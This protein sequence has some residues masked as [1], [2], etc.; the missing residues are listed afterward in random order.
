LGRLETDH[1]TIPKSPS[2]SLILSLSK[3]AS[4]G[5]DFGRAGD[6]TGPILSRLSTSVGV[7]H[8]RTTGLQKHI[9]LEDR[10]LN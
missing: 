6:S 5:D 7:H 2:I 4:K 3:D 9:V 1:A 10:F 8:E